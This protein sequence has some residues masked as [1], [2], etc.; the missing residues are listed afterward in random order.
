LLGGRLFDYQNKCVSSCAFVLL[1]AILYIITRKNRTMLNFL[2][3]V[4]HK[5]I[6]ACRSRWRE[7]EDS[8]EQTWTQIAIPSTTSN[9]INEKKPCCKPVG[10]ERERYGDIT[11]AAVSG[12]ATIAAFV[13]FGVM[14]MS[15]DVGFLTEQSLVWLNTLRAY[16]T[17]SKSFSAIH[18]MLRQ[19]A[20]GSQKAIEWRFGRILKQ[21]K[22]LATKTN[23]SALDNIA[24]QIKN[25]SERNKLIAIL[26][27]NNLLEESVMDEIKKQVEENQAKT[28]EN[29]IKYLQK[30]WGKSHGEK[31]V[32]FAKAITLLKRNKKTD[33]IA[34]L[35]TL[36]EWRQLTP[37]LKKAINEYK[38]A[39]NGNKQT[40]KTSSMAAFFCWFVFL[41]LFF[42][43]I[44]IQV[45]AL[46][47]LEGKITFDE[48][49]KNTDDFLVFLSPKTALY[50]L[51]DLFWGDKQS[52]AST[53]T[54][55][56][57]TVFMISLRVSIIL[58]TASLNFLTGLAAKE[59]VKIGG[60]YRDKMINLI[61]DI[62]LS[63]LKK[64]KEADQEKLSSENKMNQQ[65][66]KENV[67]IDLKLEDL[68]RDYEEI[69]TERSAL[70][71]G[72]KMLVKK[73]MML[74]LATKELFFEHGQKS[75]KMANELRQIKS[76]AVHQKKDLLWYKS[77]LS[78][79]KNKY[80]R[81]K[82]G[83]QRPP[84]HVGKKEVKS[85]Q[86]VRRYNLGIFKNTPA[87]LKKAYLGSASNTKKSIIGDK[88]IPGAMK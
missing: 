37:K 40:V 75:R 11:F 34:N 57:I 66:R 45:F 17:G 55:I 12:G 20:T 18:Q 25:N 5:T 24:M 39:I 77:K 74:R 78:E 41:G 70:K 60:N 47:E 88:K 72:N 49:F 58:M 71:K 52:T 10:C 44:A 7:D 13:P 4:C 2:K 21:L 46:Y 85:K 65:L 48:I 1:S 76:G 30:K 38:K 56:A 22:K 27:K 69:K 63:R 36:A 15:F 33:G 86:A 23:V 82:S 62:P 29:I 79:Y 28:R 68:T 84:H 87:I 51:V 35:L 6:N 59:G 32:Y 14:E 54:F 80:D 81:L 42:M 61:S 16:K 43:G 19:P 31:T 3:R 8:Y 53:F 9:G 67:T 73:T 64:E 26:S 50:V 83:I